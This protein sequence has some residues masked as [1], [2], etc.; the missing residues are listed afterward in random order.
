[1]CY[2]LIITFLPICFW[3]RRMTCNFK[4]KKKLFRK[5]I[6]T[7]V[8][9]NLILFII[10]S[11]QAVSLT[12][13]TLMGGVVFISA[14]GMMTALWTTWTTLT[15]PG[16]IFTPWNSLFI[17]EIHIRQLERGSR[18]TGL[19]PPHNYVRP[20][21]ILLFSQHLN[22]LSKFSSPYSDLQDKTTLLTWS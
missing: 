13:L 11:C 20:L 4:W 12:S 10:L 9:L 7:T 22:A 18:V 6:S 16:S 5:V 2:T 1:M 3:N 8:K 21:L 17:P 14:P 19:Q 15:T